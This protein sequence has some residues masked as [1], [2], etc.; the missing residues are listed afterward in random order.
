MDPKTKLVLMLAG[1]CV[2]G[3][4]LGIY[5]LVKRWRTLEKKVHK[6]EERTR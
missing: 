3:I 6:M 2:P 4:C 5:Y 1:F